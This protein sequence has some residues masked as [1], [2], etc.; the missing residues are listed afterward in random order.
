MLFRSTINNKENNYISKY[1]NEYENIM[2]FFRSTDINYLRIWLRK[3]ELIIRKTKSERYVSGGLKTNFLNIN[4]YTKNE[5]LRDFDIYVQEYPELFYPEKFIKIVGLDTD[6]T[7]HKYLV[8]NSRNNLIIKKI[9]G[10]I[11][12]HFQ[13]KNIQLSFNETGF[14]S[15][16]YTKLLDDED[17]NLIMDTMQPY[18]ELLLEDII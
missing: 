8:E 9:T 7:P 13:R 2:D 4:E 14:L 6:I 10:S 17:N 18:L 5:L 12:G 15:Y 3:Y 1:F 16:I 11:I